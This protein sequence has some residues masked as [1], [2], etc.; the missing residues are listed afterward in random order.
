MASYLG[1]NGIVKIVNDVVGETTSFSIEE[2]AETVETTAMG[3][4]YREYKISYKN[5][6]GSAEMHWDP[7]DVGQTALAVGASVTIGFYPEGDSV[8][9]V[10]LTGTA[11]VTSLTREAELDGLVSASVELQGTGALINSA[12][13]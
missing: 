4:E 3:D 6:T 5:W 10:I 13:S 12:V 11:L 1:K 2:T 9:D 7:D 8:G